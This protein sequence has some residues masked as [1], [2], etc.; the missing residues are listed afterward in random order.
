M[1]S[2]VVALC[3]LDGGNIISATIA[4]VNLCGYLIN[5]FLSVG[6]ILQSS[7]I[8]DFLNAEFG[9]IGLELIH[10]LFVATTNCLVIDSQTSTAQLRQNT[11]GQLAEGRRDILNLLLTL[12]RVFIHRKHA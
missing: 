8:K 4:G 12:L 9:S 2:L 11:I 1:S 10:N 5:V 7:T 3:K 6:I